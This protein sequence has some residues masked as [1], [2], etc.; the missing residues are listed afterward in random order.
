LGPYETPPA[1]FSSGRRRIA[2]LLINL[3]SVMAYLRKVWNQPKIIDVTRLTF[4]G[5]RPNY[6][7]KTM[8]I[9]AAGCGELQR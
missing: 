5:D 8:N 6:R 4:L 2:K 9:P 1:E 7:S 3:V